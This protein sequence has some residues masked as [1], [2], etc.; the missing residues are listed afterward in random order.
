VQPVVRLPFDHVRDERT[1]DGRHLEAMTTAARGYTEPGNSRVMIHPV[2]SIERI[3]I[4]AAP[5]TCD[6]RI[7]KCRDGLIQ[8]GSQRLLVFRVN[9][10]FVVSWLYCKASTV[11]TDLDE[12]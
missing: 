10:P 12:A 3:S 9:T 1:Q 8:E 11:P 6:G 5:G 7:R 2:V 4:Q